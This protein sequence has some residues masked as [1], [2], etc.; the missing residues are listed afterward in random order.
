MPVSL[1]H[2]AERKQMDTCTLELHTAWRTPRVRTHAICSETY[3]A[4]R[5][6][7]TTTRHVSTHGTRPDTVP[8]QCV[9]VLT[10]IPVKVPMTTDTICCSLLLFDTTCLHV[11]NWR[12]NTGS[13]KYC[14]HTPRK[15]IV[16]HVQ[17][18]RLKL[19]SMALWIYNGSHY[20]T[21]VP[22][23]LLKN[24]RSAQLI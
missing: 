14:A 13:S 1:S 17:H 7:C 24:S 23:R 11:C 22:Q 8:I 19:R 9:L 18:D 10:R 2:P 6:L 16:S 4:Y 3:S 5:V 20:M 21:F 15:Y 12:G